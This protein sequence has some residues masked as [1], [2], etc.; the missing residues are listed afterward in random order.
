MY[1]AHEALEQKHWWFNG[2]RKIVARIFETQV[3]TSSSTRILDVGCGTGGM[4]PLLQEFGHVEGAEFSADARAR[5]KRRFPHL[6]IHECVLPNE[7]PEGQWDVVTAFDV[8]E[9]VDD[10]VSSLV[11]MRQR[12]KPG[13]TILVTV[14]AFEIL[15]GRHDD[16]NHHKRRYTKS[17]LMQQLIAAGLATRFVSY[18]NTFL[19]PAAAAVRLLQRGLVSKAMGASEGETGDLHE[20]WAPAN[21]ALVELFRLEA[22]ILTRWQFPFG[23]SLIAAATAVDSPKSKNCQK[24]TIPAN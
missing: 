7:L 5:A 13:G 6:A 3:P 1:G 4:F 16:L 2:R 18:F 19:F 10:A 14:P 17:Q 15:W 9:H 22:N 8:I 24:A 11:S 12:L 21:R 23:L 20:V